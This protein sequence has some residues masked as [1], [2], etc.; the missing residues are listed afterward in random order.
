M[1]LGLLRR[2]DGGLMHAIVKRRKLDYEGKI[3]GIM[4]NNSL[5]D[6][7]AYEVEFYDSTTKFLPANIVSENLLVQVDD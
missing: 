7:R 4:N 6:T 1:K 2:E 3:V 5:L